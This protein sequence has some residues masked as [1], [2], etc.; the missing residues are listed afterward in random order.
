[1]MPSDARLRMG[2]RSGILTMRHEA[3]KAAGAARSAKP[4]PFK[5]SLGLHRPSREISS[6]ESFNRSLAG[7]SRQLA[8][9]FANEPR[10]TDDVPTEGQPFAVND[11]P[12]GHHAPPENLGEARHRA[13]ATLRPPEDRYAYLA[14]P[15]SRISPYMLILAFGFGVAAAAGALYFSSGGRLSLNFSSLFSPET[16]AD[17]PPSLPKAVAAVPPPPAPPPAPVSVAPEVTVRS[18]E[19]VVAP[20]L[21]EASAVASVEPT[22]AVPADNGSLKPEEILELQTLLKSF[23]FDPGPLDGYWGPLTSGAIRRFE[24]SRGQQQTGNVDRDTLRLLRQNQESQAPRP[25]PAKMVAP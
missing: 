4:N 2:Q 16:V 7:F 13:L 1:M 17:A 20:P 10:T 24:E 9:R 3:K 5:A 11:L 15:P 22:P 21:V 8:E 23:G 19:P 18:P 14:E 12:S 25:Q 6:D